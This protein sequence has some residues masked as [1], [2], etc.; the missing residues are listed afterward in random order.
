MSIGVT[1]LIL[2]F[3]L[4][5]Q[6]F[7]FVGAGKCK[8]CHR[9]DTQGRQYPIWEES[10]HSQSFAILSSE[11]AAEVAKEC[12]ESNPPEN[13]KCLKCHSP[14]SEKAPELKEEGVTCEV[15]HGPGSEYKKMSIMKNREEALK[16]GLILYET[17][18]AIKERCLTCHKDAHGKTFD[19]SSAWEKIKHK[20]PE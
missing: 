1:V 12:G 16:T 2:A 9:T 11:K 3:L 19:F 15:C 14:L 6:E 7:T 18:E 17:D 13:P 20:K 5:G 8:I 10:K 4:I